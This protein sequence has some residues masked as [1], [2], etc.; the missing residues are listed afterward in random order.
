MI[1]S[2]SLIVLVLA[3]ISTTAHANEWKG[4]GELGWTMTSG[5]TDTENLV[6]ALS[7]SKETEKWLHSG[8]LELLNAA[9]DGT[10]TAERYIGSGKTQYKYTEKSYSYLSLRYENDRFS[11]F[12]YRAT[13]AVGVGTRFIENE[14]QTLDGSI[15]VGVARTKLKV[16]GDTSDEAVLRLDGRYTHKLSASASF[17]QDVLIEAGSDNTYAESVTGLRVNI[18]SS[19]ATRISYTVKHNTD[20]PSD[21]DKTDTVSAVTLVYSF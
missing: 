19:L 4:E 6:G 13:L 20:A 15:G 16:S 12:D 8:S 3:G 21:T 10:R 1:N 18:N 11:G 9:T 14:T 7:V 2:R 5:N 17:S